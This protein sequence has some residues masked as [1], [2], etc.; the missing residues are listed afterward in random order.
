MMSGSLY[1]LRSSHG[2][3]YPFW[4]RKQCK[5]VRSIRSTASQTLDNR[6]RALHFSRYRD[7]ALRWAHQPS[8]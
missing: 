1:V 6:P 8:P 2:S 3:N 4:T 7:K 5:N